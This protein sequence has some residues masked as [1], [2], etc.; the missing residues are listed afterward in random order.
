[1][2][3]YETKKHRAIRKKREK[4]AKIIAMI[5]PVTLVL[6]LG[7]VIWNGK[8]SLEASN[9]KYTLNKQ[10]LE[11]KITEEEVRRESLKEYDKYVQTKPYIE[12]I[13]RTKFNLVYPD[14]VVFKATDK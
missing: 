3:K 4:R 5:I 9:T 11:E 10:I 8:S 1:M 14:E 12:E 6:A 13:A 7:V 2:R